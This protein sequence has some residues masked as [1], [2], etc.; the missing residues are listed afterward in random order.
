MKESL[1]KKRRITLKRRRTK[2][3][4]TKRRRRERKSDEYHCWKMKTPYC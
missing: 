3:R 1:K 4:R 2:R